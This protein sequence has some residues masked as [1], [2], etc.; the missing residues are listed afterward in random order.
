MTLQGTDKEWGYY[1][2]EG[3]QSIDSSPYQTMV[4]KWHK[5]HTTSHTLSDHIS[6]I[7]YL[8]AHNCLTLPP[9][10]M[11]DS[12]WY[13]HVHYFT[14]HSLLF[15]LMLWLGLEALVLLGLAQRHNQEFR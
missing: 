1:M 3:L 4:S 2:Y 15:M 14:K 13:V 7:S 6:H 5:N 9:S 10:P 11:I 8:P 12:H